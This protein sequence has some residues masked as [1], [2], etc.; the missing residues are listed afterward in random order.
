[1]IIHVIDANSGL[2]E[3][4]EEEEDANAAVDNGLNL[5]TDDM[6]CPKWVRCRGA[7]TILKKTQCNPI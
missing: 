2:E 5:L 4:I 6:L 3:V 1:M 7:H